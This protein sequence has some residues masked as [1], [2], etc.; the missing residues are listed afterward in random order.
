MENMVKEGKIKK[1]FYKRIWFIILI[2]LGVFSAI[3]SCGSDEE[4]AAI[5]APE[6]LVAIEPVAEEDYELSEETLES[7]ALGIFEDSFEGIALVALNGDINTFYITP[8]DEAFVLG[9]TMALDGD[10]DSI[11]E[12]DTLVGA[13]IVLSENIADMLPGYTIE[14]V[15]PENTDNTLL[16]VIDGIV[17]YDVINGK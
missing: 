12:W 3:V 15:N 10:Q 16:T 8:F 5:P 4:P 6:E 7:L 2:V 9:L 11:A 17:T 1:P 13:M 14:L